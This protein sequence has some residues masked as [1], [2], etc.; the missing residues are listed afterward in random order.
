[1]RSIM[2]HNS[3]FTKGQHFLSHEI[4]GTKDI[5]RNFKGKEFLS[6]PTN[7]TVYLILWCRFH[8]GYTYLYCDTPVFKSMAKCYFKIN[9]TYWI[10]GICT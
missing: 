4:K 8:V 1:M 10:V 2:L 6:S 5:T 9:Y 3:D 7:N